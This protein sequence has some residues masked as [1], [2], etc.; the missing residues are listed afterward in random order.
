MYSSSPGAKI[1]YALY[2]KIL[3]DQKGI[4]LYWYLLF[5]IEQF[6]N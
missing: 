6:V 5:T 2:V 4:S 3:V 1:A